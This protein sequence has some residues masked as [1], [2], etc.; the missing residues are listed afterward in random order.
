MIRFINVN[1]TSSEDETILKD[2]SF[3]LPSRGFVFLSGKSGSGK[4][5]LCNLL[6]GLEKVSF[7]NI[8]VAQEDLSTFS[9]SEM[10][11]YRNGMVSNIIQ[12]SYFVNE[13]TILENILLAIK[14]QKRVV[15]EAIHKQ[16]RELFKYFDLSIGL[17]KKKS[18][19]LSGGQLQRAN[20][21]RSLIKNNNLLIADEPTGNLDAESSSL[22]FK[23]LKEIS[24]EK[25]VVVVTHDILLATKYADIIIKI[26]KGTIKDFLVRQNNQISDTSVNSTSEDLD[27]LSYVN[28][29]EK[30]YF[31]SKINESSIL[32]KND[33]LLDFRSISSDL[34]LK[35]VYHIGKS[36]TKA[37]LKKNMFMIFINALIFILCQLAI[38][39]NTFLSKIIWYKLSFFKIF[40]LEFDEEVLSFWSNG[41][42]GFIFA[43]IK[44]L[45]LPW[46]IFIIAKAFVRL[47]FMIFYR[48]VGIS[49]YLGSN[50]RTINKMLLYLFACFMGFF[51][52]TQQIVFFLLQ[53][54][55]S[56]DPDNDFN[57]YSVFVD[58]KLIPD[59]KHMSYF[60]QKKALIKLS[61]QVVYKNVGAHSLFDY[62]LCSSGFFSLSPNYR[63]IIGFIGLFIFCLAFVWF[64]YTVIYSNKLNKEKPLMML[65]KDNKI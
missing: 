3:N 47:Q 18:F 44:Y 4:T 59:F 45:V 1:L 2:I 21:I 35:E 55:I 10:A 62:N 61:R 34:P 30:K 28:H 53:K 7:G 9:N 48:T 17:L 38:V 58:R 51:A 54:L 27:I 41:I 19:E 37:H 46:Y 25:L 23:R 56:I 39:S 22:V 13:L 63:D 14:L 15:N 26:N 43:L 42:M 57:Y 16:I 36:L 29:F 64:L 5:S 32:F 52:L 65:K 33:H 40:Y 49:R 24:E 11:N 12:D 50:K 20:I 60:D 31:V 8:I 6:S